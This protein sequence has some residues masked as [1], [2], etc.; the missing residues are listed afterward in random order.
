MTLETHLSLYKGIKHRSFGK[1]PLKLA[2]GK[3]T[4]DYG[5]FM[6]EEK[7]KN[8]EIKMKSPGFL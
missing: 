4:T 8:K 5:D 6:V 3:Q 1:L 2:S 7:S